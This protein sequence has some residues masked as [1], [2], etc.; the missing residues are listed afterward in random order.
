MRYI[1]L[2]LHG[3]RWVRRADLS[4][5]PGIELAEVSAAGRIIHLD[6]VMQTVAFDD[7]AVPGLPATP[8]ATPWTRRLGSDL[9]RIGEAGK[10]VTRWKRPSDAACSARRHRPSP[11]SIST[12]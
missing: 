11:I 2:W 3:A 12:A 4:A 10:R 5:V 7:A 1:I 9:L 6:C 8:P